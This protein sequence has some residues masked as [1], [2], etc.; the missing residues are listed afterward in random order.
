M[1]K[2]SLRICLKIFHK[3]HEFINKYKFYKNY[4]LRVMGNS[5]D[6]ID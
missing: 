4:D 2:I 6:V 5:S 3:F 1:R